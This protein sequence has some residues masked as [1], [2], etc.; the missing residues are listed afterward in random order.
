MN[1]VFQRPGLGADE[2]DYQWSLVNASGD[3]LSSHYSPEA[4]LL[5]ASDVLDVD[6]ATLRLVRDGDGRFNVEQ[7]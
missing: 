7:R 6:V 5:R 3:L 1:I 2:H 4:A